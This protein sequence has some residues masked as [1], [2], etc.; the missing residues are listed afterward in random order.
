LA[1]SALAETRVLFIPKRMAKK[2]RARKGAAPNQVVSVLG[3]R[4]SS[5]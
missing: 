2:G 5:D 3:T 4:L 1:I